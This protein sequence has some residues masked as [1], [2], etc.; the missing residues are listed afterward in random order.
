MES[1]HRIISRQRENRWVT[2]VAFTIIVTFTNLHFFSFFVVSK[3]SGNR[4]KEIFRNIAWQPKRDI[5]LP[6]YT[7]FWHH[8]HTIKSCFSRTLLYCFTKKKIIKNKNS[9]ANSEFPDIEFI[10]RKVKRICIM[11]F[12]VNKTNKQNQIN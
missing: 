7:H 2:L 8:R 3:K 4:K 5:D 6:F 1:G 12:L 11:F 10:G 9:W